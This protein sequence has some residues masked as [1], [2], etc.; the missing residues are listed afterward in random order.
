MMPDATQSAPAAST[1]R[2][3]RAERAGSPLVLCLAVAAL[4]AALYHGVGHYGFSI[5]DDSHYVTGNPR[6]LAGFTWGNVKNV[7]TPGEGLYWSPVTLLSLMLDAKLFGFWA[8]GFH[9]MNALWHCANAALFCLLVLRLTGSRLAAVAAASLFAAHPAHVEAVAWVT[10][11]KDVLSTFLGLSAVHLYVSWARRPSGVKNVLLH[12]LYL[13]SLMAKPMFVT[14][15]GLLL[16]LDWWPLGRLRAADGGPWPDRRLLV[17]RLREKA[18]LL[19]LGAFAT[20]MT[21]S[22]H[23]AGVFDRLDP[24]LGLKLANAVVSYAKYLGLLVWPHDQAI[25]YPFPDAVP[26][27]HVVLSGA[28]LAA[29]T[30][31]CLRQ[32]RARP[33]LLVGW[34]WFLAALTPVI[35]PP[36][37]G[38]H[39][40]YADRWAYVPFMGLYLAL[41]CLGAELAGRIR[42]DGPRMAV[43]AA[44]V[45]LPL[46]ALIPVQQRQL[47]TWKT[48]FGIAEQALR[49]TRGNYLLMN[50]YGILKGLGGDKAA[51]EA[52]YLAALE[53]YPDYGP[54]LYN[55]GLL[56]LE[57]KRYAEA[58]QPL[59]RGMEADQRRGAK[60]YDAYCGVALCLTFLGRA[61]EAPHYYAL[62]IREDPA[63]PRAYNDWGNLARDT[64]NPLL[65][66]ELYRKSLAADPDYA[67]AK[68]NLEKLTSG[69][70]PAP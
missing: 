31:L 6:I 10:A 36:K 55:L 29:V 51:A 35:M 16:L 18:L 9:L 11:R 34:L 47:A 4:A 63:S 45:L 32:M 42:R 22:S 68:R 39:V 67:L 14:L 60:A 25:V 58:L 57:Q 23:Y 27:L 50:N 24:S 1:G 66:L 5:L 65:A 48:P 3:A 46:V 41:G 30:A 53:A 52:A 59:L 70:K 61:D 17:L 56:R 12:A 26:A 2:A 38:L 40:E 37:V 49:V 33:Y 7:F 64:G 8:G 54:A 21:L 19:A 69:T 20:F 13:I 15:A 43:S 44:W 28:L 62:A